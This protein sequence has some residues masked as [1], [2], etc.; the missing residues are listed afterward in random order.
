MPDLGD[1]DAD[2]QALKRLD[3]DSI[4]ALQKDPDF[5]SIFNLT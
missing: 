1:L 4:R 2:Q 5:V 3:K